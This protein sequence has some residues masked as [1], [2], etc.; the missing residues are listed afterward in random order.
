MGAWQRDRVTMA[1]DACQPAPTPV[2]VLRLTE[3]CSQKL[4]WYSSRHDI[5]EPLQ[6]RRALS[7]RVFRR[8]R[9]EH[10][11]NAEDQHP[12]LRSLEEYQ[13]GEHSERHGK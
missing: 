3:A 9:G 13:R 11:H 12:S 2:R 6:H 5:T 10:E 7:C 4:R 8:A 1:K